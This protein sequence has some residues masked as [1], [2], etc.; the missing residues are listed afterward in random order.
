MTPRLAKAFVENASDQ[1]LG[2]TFTF[3]IN[4]FTGRLFGVALFLFP[5]VT[6]AVE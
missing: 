6:R 4:F 5:S 1:G 3:L 2:N